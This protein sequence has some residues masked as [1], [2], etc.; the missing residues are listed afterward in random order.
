[1]KIFTKEE[2]DDL[3]EMFSKDWCDKYYPNL[4]TYYRWYKK[5]NNSI[6]LVYLCK[7][8]HRKVHI[9]LNKFKKNN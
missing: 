7:S 6:N 3:K 4:R 2:I 9:L 8:C 5:N 1:M